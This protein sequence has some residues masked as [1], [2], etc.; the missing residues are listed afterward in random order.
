LLSGNSQCDPPRYDLNQL[1]DQL[2]RAGAA[3]GRL[4]LRHQIRLTMRRQ[5]CR[6]VLPPGAKID[7]TPWKFASQFKSRRPVRNSSNWIPMF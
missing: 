1:G 3:E 5:I 7:I 2:R 4:S 6:K